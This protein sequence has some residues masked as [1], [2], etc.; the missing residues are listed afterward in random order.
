M[1][2]GNGDFRNDECVEILKK[3]DIVVTNPPFSLFRQ[4]V[5]Q[6]M[7]YEKS[8]IIWGNN[9]A[10]TYKEFFPLLKDNKV[11][12]GYTANKTCVFQ[13]SDDYQKWDEKLT[14]QMNDGHKYGKCPAISIFTNLD[15]KKRHEKLILWKKYSPEEFPKYDNYDAINVDKVSD[16]PVDYDGVMGVPI[17]FFDRYNPEQFEIIGYTAKD[18]GVDCLK[19]YEDLEQSLDGKPFVRNMKSARFSPMIRYDVKPNKTCY[20]ASN[21]KGYMLKTYGRILI[22]KKA[23]A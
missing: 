23:G 11:W 18:M 22:R 10:I 17:T 12:L 6:L 15:I 7:E 9:N 14:A 19:F 21:V 2:E 1:L 16:I 8:F 3:S 20:R 13:L 5:V 4:Y